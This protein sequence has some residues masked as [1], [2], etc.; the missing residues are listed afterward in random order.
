MSADPD[1]EWSQFAACRD[2]PLAPFFVDRGSDAQLARNVCAACPVR[3]PCLAE[4]LAGGDDTGVWGGFTPRERRLIADAVGIT[5]TD[6]TDS[7]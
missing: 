7:G 6:G 1:L 3:A 2:L 5:R 4:A